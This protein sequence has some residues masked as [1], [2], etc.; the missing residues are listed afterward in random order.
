MET[1]W[2]LAYL[3]EDVEFERCLLTPDFTE[4]RVM[5]SSIISVGSWA[6]GKEQRQ[7]S[8]GSSNAFDYNSAMTL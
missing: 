7:A 3:S 5:E 6:C 8:N 4:I 1:A 2:T